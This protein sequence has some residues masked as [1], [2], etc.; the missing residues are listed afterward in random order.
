MLSSWM[1]VIHALRCGLVERERGG[2]QLDACWYMRCELK[3]KKRSVTSRVGSWMPGIHARTSGERGTR[4]GAIGCE[5][6][7]WADVVESKSDVDFQQLDARFSMG[8]GEREK[9]PRQG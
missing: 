6:I 2:R 8:A 5:F 1:L 4:W 9:G 7:R 3:R